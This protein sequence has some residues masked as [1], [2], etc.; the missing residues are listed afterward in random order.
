MMPQ[1]ADGISDEQLMGCLDGPGVEAAIS[2]LY[3]RYSRTVYGVGLKI[4][5]ERSLAEELVQEVFLKVWRSSSTFDPLRGSFSTWLYRVTR[6][7]ALDLYRKRAHKVDQVPD[8][9]TQLLISRDSSASPQE[10][11]DESWLSWRV[12]RALEVLNVPHK[13]VIHLAYFEGLTQREVS[14]RTG[15]PL[16]T[17]KS[18]TASAFKRLR[19]ELVDHDS[20]RKAMR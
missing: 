13:E 12:S 5:G 2:T 17:V 11:V 9:E 18:R 14:E 3:D 16:G 19:Q 8:G 6:S 10:V 20:P 1:R 15:V 7:C 4:L